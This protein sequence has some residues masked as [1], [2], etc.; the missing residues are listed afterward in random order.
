MM[1]L[2]AGAAAWNAPAAD[3]AFG[4][5]ARQR[6]YN[7]STGFC[8][9]VLPNFYDSIFVTLEVTGCTHVD[10]AIRAAFDSWAHNVDLSFA[11]TSGEADMV[12]SI[13]ERHGA[14][15]GRLGYAVVPASLDRLRR[16]I[17]I[18]LSLDTCWYAD[19]E[20]CRAVQLQYVPLTIGLVA[21]WAGAV[22]FVLTVGILRPA[23]T[24]LEAIG[25]LVAWAVVFA[26]PLIATGLYPCV[27]CFDF[28]IVV[29]HEIGHALGVGHAEESQRCGCGA[30][31]RQLVPTSTCEGS[32]Q[33]VMN[34]RFQAAS[35]LCLSRDDLD[36]VRTLWGSDCAQENT[37][38]SAQTSSILSQIAIV[39]LYTFV[40]AWLTVATRLCIVR[41]CARASS[42]SKPL[43]R[44]TA[45][46]P[47]K[48]GHSSDMVLPPGPSSSYRLAAPPPSPRSRGTSIHPADRPPP[49]TTSNVALP[50]MRI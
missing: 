41:R 6:S 42:A 49:T 18:N 8:E 7:L 43:F 48:S 26:C 29:A 11:F 9:H 16:P 17:P 47:R 40:A 24:G 21:L 45:R 14:D 30:D 3:G 13:F 12:F 27:S 38:F 39:W 2:L 28:E 4:A 34:S 35:S 36:A 23:R 15:D 37:C 25:R 20:L 50:P 32:S 5:V 10:R 22:V 19:R 44:R 31:A 33:N 46:A 1:T